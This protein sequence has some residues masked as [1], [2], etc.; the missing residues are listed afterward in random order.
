M[1]D[2]LK[3]LPG[4]LYTMNKTQWYVGPYHFNEEKMIKQ[5][6]HLLK[7]EPIDNDYTDLSE[8]KLNDIITCASSVFIRGDY[9]MAFKYTDLA[10][11]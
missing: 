6:K 1:Y 9:S 8:Q 7:D 5:L 4:E 2:Y 3:N 10:K 11:F